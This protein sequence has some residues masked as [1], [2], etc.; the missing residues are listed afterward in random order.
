M[1]TSIRIE[2]AGRRASLLTQTEEAAMKRIGKAD[3]N[4]PDW[5]RK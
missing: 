1:G 4:R 5:Y 2:I 3:A